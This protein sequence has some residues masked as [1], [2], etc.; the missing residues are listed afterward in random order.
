MMKSRVKKVRATI[1]ILCS[2][3]L[4]VA[5]TVGLN[6]KIKA[7]N[8]SVPVS[9]SNTFHTKTFHIADSTNFLEIKS[10]T[11]EFTKWGISSPL[12][13]GSDRDISKELNKLIIENQADAITGLKISVN[14]SEINQVLLFPKVISLWVGIAA[15]ALLASGESADNALV[16]AGAAIIY[17][18]TPAKT[19]I[20]V[21]GMVVR[22]E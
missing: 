7:S 10:F 5:C 22:L 9:F 4:L 12:N 3:I 20:K 19:N 11:L 18:F 21:E 6:T 8:L 17:L 2:S 15:M 16:A 13:I 1:Y 14:N